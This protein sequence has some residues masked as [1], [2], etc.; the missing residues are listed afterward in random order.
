MSTPFIFRQGR[1]VFQRLARPTKAVQQRS[2]HPDPFNPKV[3][4]GWKAALKVRN[5]VSYG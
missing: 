1:T 4:K 5:Y 2:H 3:T